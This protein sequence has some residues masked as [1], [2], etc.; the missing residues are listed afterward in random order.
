MID[1]DA[2]DT[3]ADA[4]EEEERFRDSNDEEEE[5][6]VSTLHNDSVNSKWQSPPTWPRHAYMKPQAPPEDSPVMFHGA[7]F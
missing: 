2:A 1:A 7:G 4:D 3:D 5:G 6:G